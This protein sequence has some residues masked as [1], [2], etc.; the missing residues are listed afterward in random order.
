M[1]TAP[2]IGQIVISTTG[3]DKGK[4]YLVVGKTPEG[5]LL[6]SDGRKRGMSCMKRK[7]FRHVKCVD[8]EVRNGEDG[9]KY[10]DLTVRA[11]LAEH[12]PEKL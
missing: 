7:N 12:S 6:L 3:R 8:S 1:K 11:A 2:E 9:K 5:R 4:L 10:S